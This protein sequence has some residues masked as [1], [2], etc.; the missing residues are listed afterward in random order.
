MAEAIRPWGCMECTVMSEIDWDHLA[1]LRDDVGAED[2]ADIVLLFFAEIGEKLDQMQGAG[3]APAVDD[4]H[5]L[6][7]SAANLGFTDMVEA[8]RKAEAACAGGAKPDL[9]AVVRSYEGAL[10]RAR[11]R[12]PELAVA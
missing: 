4:F 8:C 7:G 9:A 11:A 1:S 6:R 10:E 2:F 5:F 3:T 12:V